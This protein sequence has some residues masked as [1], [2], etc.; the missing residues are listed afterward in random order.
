MIFALN[1]IFLIHLAA[2]PE[3]IEIPLKI[4]FS[5]ISFFL[6]PLKLFVILFILGLSSGKFLSV[7][8]FFAQSAIILLCLIS[9]A[10]FFFARHLFKYSV[11]ALFLPLGI[12]LSGGHYASSYKKQNI[13]EFTDSGKLTVEGEVLS[14]VDKGA[15]KR[16]SILA[17]TLIGEGESIRLNGE[18]LLNLASG[19]DSVLPG[20]RVRFFGYLKRPRNFG[21]PGGFDYEAYLKE[22]GIYATSFLSDDRQMALIGDASPFWQALYSFRK[23]AEKAI[24]LATSG[25]ATAVP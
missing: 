24:F 2:H 15:Q 3:L 23:R 10:I 22:R 14:R 4:D 19:G 25:D 9:L 5:K 20:D 8:P 16:L 7:P 21:N 12:L 18:I 6:H 11:F 13:V 1:L 17:D